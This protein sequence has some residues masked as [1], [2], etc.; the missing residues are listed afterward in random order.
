MQLLH[1]IRNLAR[2][3]VLGINRRTGQYLLRYN[4]RR[5]YPLVDDKLRTKRL[6]EKF[7]IAV[8]ETYGVIE[9]HRQIRGLPRLLAE[10][11]DFVVKP[12]RGSGGEGIL[13]IVGRTK[14]G[15]KKANGTIVG[16][17]ELGHHLANILSGMYSLGGQADVALIEYRVH[18]H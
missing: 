3:G 15:Y 6:A 17:D 11:P 9:I 14:N 1:D 12:A 5:L 4:P 7:A 10:H 2:R 8:P 13:V 18:P 16:A